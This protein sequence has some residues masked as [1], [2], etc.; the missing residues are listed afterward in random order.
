MAEAVRRFVKDQSGATSIEYAMLAVGVAIAIIV[1]V[2]N[3]GSA[4]NDNYSSV[5]SALQ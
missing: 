3:L 2:S 1:A 4:V 5:E